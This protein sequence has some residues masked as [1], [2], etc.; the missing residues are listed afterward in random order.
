MGVDRRFVCQSTLF[1]L[2]VEVAQLKWD[3]PEKWAIRQA[4]NLIQSCCE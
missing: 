2:I 1:S 3:D 4:K